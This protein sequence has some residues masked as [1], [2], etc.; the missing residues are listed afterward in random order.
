MREKK[1]KLK[2]KEREQLLRIEEL[3]KLLAENGGDVDP[4]TI[5]SMY[6]PRRKA[7]RFGAA[8]LRLDRMWLV[9]MG[10]IL[11]VAV[12]FISAF[13]Q[14]KMGNFTINLN[15]LDLFRRGISIAD[16]GEFYNATSRLTA[17]AIQ[18]ATNI[19]GNDLPEDL[20]EVEGEHNGRNYM[21]YTYFL[22]NA[23]K[24]D[25]DYRAV[26]TLDSCAKGAEEAVR[27]A[28]WRN[29]VRTVYAAPSEN[30]EPEEGCVNFQSDKVVCTYDVV[31]FLVG[32]VDKYT[33][34]T[35]MEGDDPEC[36]D[37]II[38]G[39]IEFTMNIEALGEDDRGL[40]A[41]FIQDIGDTL[42]G[43]KPIDSSGT[44]APSYFNDEQI[45][46]TNRGNKDRDGLVYPLNE[47]SQKL[48]EGREAKE[49]EKA[50]E[51]E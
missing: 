17:G 16:N 35:W 13:F 41:K 27:I 45:T 36:V 37:A 7:R 51:K 20:D 29:G 30:G 44:K 38:G 21:A 26:L 6:M 19:S 9:L 49:A 42:T 32:D 14:E 47:N 43:N 5:V 46:W 24:E 33:V 3:E 8:L 34:V 2:R 50:T 28:V 48:L 40:L 22:R 1:K 23:G 12:L 31:D 39:S 18:E 10:L 25:V 4:D 11:L 15:R